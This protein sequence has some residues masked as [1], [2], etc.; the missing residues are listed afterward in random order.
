MLTRAS[1][2]HV[3]EAWSAEIG[4]GADGR[5]G[6]VSQSDK[7]DGRCGHCR[8]EGVSL[9]RRICVECDFLKTL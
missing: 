2:M 6:E 9:V 1:R 3:S 7:V 5:F 4:C 8:K